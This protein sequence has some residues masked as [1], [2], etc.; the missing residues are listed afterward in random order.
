MGIK[1]AGEKYFGGKVMDK[2]ISGFRETTPGGNVIE[3]YFSKEPNKYL[4]S[5]VIT[6]INDEPTN[7][8]IQ[9]MPKIHFYNDHEDICDGTVSRCY[10]KLDGACL[11]VYPLK[12]AEGNIIEVIPKTRGKVIA[13]EEFIELFLKVDQNS[14][15]DYYSKNDGILI[16]ELYGKL[17]P[18][19]IE[20]DE[21]IDIRLIA[22]HD[23]SRFVAEDPHFKKPDLVFTLRYDGNWIISITSKK[24]KSYFADEEYSY[25]TN[26]DAIN[27]M[28]QLLIDLNEKHES[29]TGRKAIE[30]VVIN[31]LN[32]DGRPKWIKVKPNVGN[33]DFVI[34]DDTIRKEVLKYFDEYSSKVLELYNSDQNHHTEYL[35]RMLEEEF[36][37]DVIDDYSDRIE[38]I[39]MEIWNKKVRTS[40]RT[41][42]DD[43]IDDYADR[44]IDYC[45]RVF[46]KRYPMKRGEA[47]ELRE[48]LRQQML[49]YGFD[50]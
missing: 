4:G 29:Q 25:P 13:D 43:L 28:Y 3:G 10:E 23:G 24:F 14:I 50:V 40:I 42:C 16:F 6:R 5:F 36:S 38:E 1:G 21:D 45:M 31:T 32:I 9:S 47:E 7:Q 8:F 22:V 46:D 18:H 33:K 11:I 39:F 20:Y 49:K 27:G 41:I 19:L 30:G 26:R 2:N 12:D 15:R 34:M 35:Y 17:N 48:L 37:I 44:G